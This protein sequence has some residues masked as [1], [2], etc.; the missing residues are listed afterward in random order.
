MDPSAVIIWQSFFI[1][2]QQRKQRNLLVLLNIV[3]D[4]Q[5][6]QVIMLLMRVFSDHLLAIIMAIVVLCKE[7]KFEDSTPVTCWCAP[8]QGTSTVAYQP[9]Y[10][11]VNF[12]FCVSDWVNAAIVK[13]SIRSDHSHYLLPYS[14][15]MTETEKF[16]WAADFNQCEPQV[17]QFNPNSVTLTVMATLAS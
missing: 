13:C 12:H 3:S 9:T 4:Q 5:R 2:N 7:G 15:C 1:Q 11:C 6:F 17:F 16:N 8:G 10:L 14:T